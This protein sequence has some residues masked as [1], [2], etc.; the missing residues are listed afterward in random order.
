MG[1]C[2]PPG[3]CSC[4]PGYAGETCADWVTA[5]GSP[6]HLYPQAQVAS[7]Y[8][9]W[10]LQQA[11]SRSLDGTP[12][13]ARPDLRA[14]LLSPAAQ[15][16]I[17]ELCIF[18]ELAPPA[19]V[20]KGSVECPLL[21]LRREA[22][23]AGE[24]WPASPREAAAALRRL[25]YTDVRTESLVGW[26]AGGEVEWLAVRLLTNT[27]KV[28]EADQIRPDANWFESVLLAHEEANA[29]GSG[30][31]GWVTC[32]A[33]VWMEATEEAVDGTGATLANAACFT[34][35]CL[36]VLTGSLSVACGTVAGVLVILLC[37]LGY[38]ASRG[39]PFG[40]VEAVALTVFIGFACDYCVH[41]AQLH[42]LWRPLLPLRGGEAVFSRIL[43][44]AG[45][46]LYGAALTTVGACVPLLW[47]Q[48]IVFVEFGELI[49]VCALISLAVALTLLAPALSLAED[50]RLHRSM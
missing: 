4:L 28:T 46:S 36:L 22:E 14:D 18:L 35:A 29:Y 27:L 7:L 25:V 9:V 31:R 33:F 50:L 48:V 34:L 1:W 19:H 32:D 21:K 40:P 17:T 47:C 24:S 12:R 45:P 8:V 15:L 11:P 5:D 16:H 30:L 10:G 43:T 26:S 37:F 42:H 39:L 20:R 44:H 6:L 3:F 41:I 38:V 13:A 23:A 2:E 49:L